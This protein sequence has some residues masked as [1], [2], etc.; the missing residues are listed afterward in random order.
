MAAK[1]SKKMRNLIIGAVVLLLLIAALVILLL[2]PTQTEEETSSEETSY[3]STVVSLIES[4]ADS[5][6]E[7]SVQNAAG[8]YTIVRTRPASD[9][10]DAVYSI[11][12]LADFTQLTSEYTSLIGQFCNFSA[13]R[14]IEENAPDIAKYGLSSPAY[15]ISM[16]YD[17]GTEHTILVGNLLSTG[18]GYYMMFDDDGNVYSMADAKMTRLGYTAL[19]FVD[20]EVIDVW[21]SYTDDDGNEVS[22][23]V[24]DYLQVEGGTLGDDVLRIEPIDDSERNT[25]VS[26]GSSYELVSPFQVDMKYR[27]DEEGNDLNLTYTTGL[28]QLTADAVV[29][30][31][32]TGDDFAA[33]GIGEPYCTISFSRDGS[34]Y[35]W[36]VGNAAEDGSAAHYVYS[37]QQPIIYQVADDNLPW[38]SIN[39]DDMYTSLTLLPYI[40]D[41]AQI[42]LMIYDDTYTFTIDE[43]ADEDSDIVPHLDGEEIELANYRKMYQYFLA[44]PAEGVNRSDETGTLVV[45]FTYTYRDGGSDTVELFDLGN[46]TCVLSINGNRQWTTRLSYVQHMQ[47]NIEKLL[48]GETPSLD[49]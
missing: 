44:A 26:Y 37:T 43:A 14:L 29:C 47:S 3:T 28:Q 38:I 30:L 42:D 10:S 2:N 39:I 41:V 8:G 31:N 15:T 11:E 16:V 17:D 49:Y 25:A 40:D 48:A 46:R 33:Y 19:D 27:S 23:P 4:D 1:M 13:T 45:S 5:V 22:A 36:M 7:I 18:S 12:E 6:K 21:E 24:I 9:D 32:P 20:K 35:V 34:E